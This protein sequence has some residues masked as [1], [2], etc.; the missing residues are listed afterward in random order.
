MN[1]FIV[2]PSLVLLL[3]NQEDID[4]S[5]H[6]GSEEVLIELVGITLHELVSFIGFLYLLRQLRIIDKYYLFLLLHSLLNT[7]FKQF[8]IIGGLVERVLKRA[9]L[10]ADLVGVGKFGGFLGDS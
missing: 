2:F 7:L 3:A 1:K 5:L 10:L 4:I 8:S 9:D 6:L